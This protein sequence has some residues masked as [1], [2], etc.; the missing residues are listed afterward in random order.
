MLYHESEGQF[1]QAAEWMDAIAN[2]ITTTDMKPG[3][4]EKKLHD[5]AYSGA[6]QFGYAL[7]AEASGK[8]K[9]DIKDKSAILIYESKTT[10]KNASGDPKKDERAPGAKA[11]TLDGKIVSLP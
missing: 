6:D 11:V 7:N 5:P 10:I 9:G 1:P 2:R 8:Y 3:E 4:G